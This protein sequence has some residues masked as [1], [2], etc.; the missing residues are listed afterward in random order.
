MKIIAGL[1]LLVSLASAD[2]RDPDTFKSYVEGSRPGS[3]EVSEP[4]AGAASVRSAN[5]QPSGR[6]SEPLRRLV[7]NAPKPSLAQNSYDL[8]SIGRIA[9][10]ASLGTA[11][12]LVVLGNLNVGGARKR[13]R[14]KIKPPEPAAA[15]EPA[16]KPDLEPLVSD[17]GTEV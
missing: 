13:T 17:E 3:G 1:L 6:P 14:I 8:T 15:Q 7:P 12:L 10:G 4:P 16:F 9:L 5:L 11:I 2:L